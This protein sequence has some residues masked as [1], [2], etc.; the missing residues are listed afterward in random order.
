[1]RDGDDA[2]GD[3]IEVATPPEPASLV[4][5]V[6]CVD[7]DDPN[8]VFFARNNSFQDRSSLFLSIFFFL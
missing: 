2:G 5:G 4:G 7:G 1:M 6:G 3:A 8:P